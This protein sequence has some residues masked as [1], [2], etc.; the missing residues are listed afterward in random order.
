MIALLFEPV[1][2]HERAVIPDAIE[3]LD[4]GGDDLVQASWLLNEV[5]FLE[6]LVELVAEVITQDGGESVDPEAVA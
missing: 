6:Q 4:L 2:V 3:H 5:G 1:L